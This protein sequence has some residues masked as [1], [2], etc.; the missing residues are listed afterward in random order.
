ME[1]S[2]IPSA[3][4]VLYDIA[5]ALD[6]A[7]EPERRVGTVGEW[8]RRIVPYERCALSVALPGRDPWFLEWPQSSEIERRKLREALS[9]LLI[10]L[11]DKVSA[12]LDPFQQGAGLG[13]RA[14]LA[15]PLVGFDD[16]FGVLFVGNTISDLYTEEHLKLLSLVASQL[17]AFFTKVHLVESLRTRTHELE[18]VNRSKDDFLALL[19]H[20]L[21]TPLNAIVG[22]AKL[23]QTGNLDDATTARGL[24]VIDRNA[25]LQARLIEDTLDMSRIVTGKLRL[26]FGSVDLSAVIASV[27]ESLRFMA[28]AK[29]IR[30]TV[31]CNESIEAV[32]GD[33]SRLHQ[34]VWNLLANAIKFT[35][36]R[37]SVE[38]RLDREGS[39]VRL[40]V[41][42]NGVGIPVE[43]L[44]HVFDQFRQADSSKSRKWG[45]LG[46][47][48]AL[49]R[50]LVELHAG[51]VW[52]E[53]AGEGQGA[54]F[55]VDLPL[56]AK[57]HSDLNIAMDSTSLETQEDRTSLESLPSLVGRRVLIVDDD[58]DSLEMEAEIARQCQAYVLTARSA[59]EAYELIQ[60][61][62]L[63][64]LVA[65]IGM[66][67]E[68][69]YALLRK[70]RELSPERGGRIPAVALSGYANEEDRRQAALVGFQFHLSKPVNPRQF[71]TVLASLLKSK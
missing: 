57:Q 8:L 53:S 37:G 13:Y 3:T 61:Q 23:L 49:V 70:V 6:S 68:D 15:V 12:D 9:G 43:F 42:D 14:H 59:S 44:P 51:R 16:Y 26:D 7:E 18:A 20:E 32:E 54:T 52:A 46:L 62:Q 34:V 28:E 55:T 66:P 67:D 25:K 29:E 17:A 58:V 27:V 71:V 22:W 63:E 36:S 35:P 30:I 50:H 19:S 45:G 33:S 56:L 10:T 1:P 48:L 64:A 40:R 31:T 39:S 4:R 11:G 65:D 41:S 60:H 38:I 24:E 2:S 5:H 69:G 21:R 47:G